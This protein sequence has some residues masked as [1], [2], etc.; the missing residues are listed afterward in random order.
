MHMPVMGSFCK[1]YALAQMR[2]FK[3]WAE[4]PADTKGSTETDPDR[5][6]YLQENLT[7]TE[8]IFLDEQVIFDHVTEEWEEFCKKTLRFEVPD[9][10]RE[11]Q[12]QLLRKAPTEGAIQ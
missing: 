1:A 8:G 6:V 5:F 9:F 2:E 7:V 4:K 3:E 11:H 10:N 12:E